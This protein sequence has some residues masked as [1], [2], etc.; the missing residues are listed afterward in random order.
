VGEKTM[1]E[2][3]LTNKMI[4]SGN[5]LVNKLDERKISPDAAFWFYYPDAQEWKLIIAESKFSI[6]GPREIY[7]KIQDIILSSKEELRDLPLESVALVKPET[8]IVSL[9]NSVIKTGPGI[10]GIRFTNNVING[11]V[12]EDAYIY[13][14]NKSVGANNTHFINPK[15]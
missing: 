11:T 15:R 2:R 13:R 3:T 4:E 7:K 14:L 8:S 1:V 5:A 12:I 10:S 6:K 9:L